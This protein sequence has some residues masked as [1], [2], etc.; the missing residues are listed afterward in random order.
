MW[1][2]IKKAVNSDLD[3]PLNEMIFIQTLVQNINEDA[4]L[5]AMEAIA[6]SPNM[7]KYINNSRTLQLAVAR[8]P[9][10]EQFFFLNKSSPTPPYPSDLVTFLD[11]DNPAGELVPKVGNFTLTNTGT[12]G[13][14]GFIGQGR[15][16]ISASNSLMSNAR[17]IPIGVKSIRLYFRTS[18][19]TTGLGYLIG[20]LTNALTVNN[21]HCT[22]I[23][24][25][26]RTLQFGAS[27]LGTAFDIST[28][29]FVDDGLWHELICTYDGTTNTNGVKMWIDD[30]LVAEGTATRIQTT[31][32]RNTAMFSMSPSVNINGF[33]GDLDEIEIYNTLK[34][35]VEFS[36]FI[37]SKLL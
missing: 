29:F 3:L 28:P 27:V 13:I 33:N 8:N 9:L 14:E 21:Q 18:V 24:I 7:L 31:I 22:Y 34:T 35:N 36:L 2:V 1:G 25:N 23:R 5:W 19:Q 15:R 32:Q 11:F 26:N 17:L 37:Q 16:S 20:D 12:V 6:L 10:H 30:E 4:V